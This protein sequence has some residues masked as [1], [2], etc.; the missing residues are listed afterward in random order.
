MFYGAKNFA[1]NHLPLERGLGKREPQ[2]ANLTSRAW[3]RD[4]LTFE[5]RRKCRKTS[6]LRSLFKVTFTANG[7]LQYCI[8]WQSFPSTCCLVLI[9]SKW[10]K[11]FQAWFINKNNFGEFLSSHFHIWEIANDL[12]LKFAVCRK[13]DPKRNTPTSSVIFVIY[14][15]FHF[16]FLKARIITSQRSSVCTL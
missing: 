8:K 9:T 16:A 10:V 4:F 13:L 2:T 14:S 11:K 3:S 7:K 6:I 1:V 5:A 12:I 15:D